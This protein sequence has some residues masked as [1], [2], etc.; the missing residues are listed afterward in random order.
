MD[1]WLHLH[2]HTGL[3]DWDVGELGLVCDIMSVPVH[4]DGGVSVGQV[5]RCLVAGEVFTEMRNA[6]CTSNARDRLAADAGFK[7]ARVP[8]RE[9]GDCSTDDGKTV[10]Q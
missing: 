9:T 2:T 10:L 8:N 7:R 1:V 6:R 4:I 5:V 3:C